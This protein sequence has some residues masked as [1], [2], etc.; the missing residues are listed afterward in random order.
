M[1]QQ[2]SFYLPWFLSLSVGLSLCLSLCFSSCGFSMSSRDSLEP[3]SS[4]TGLLT[5][6]LR[7]IVHV[8]HLEGSKFFIFYSPLFITQPR[9]LC[10]TILTTF[11]S[12]QEIQ[13]KG[14]RLCFLMGIPK[15][16]VEL[17]FLIRQWQ[18]M[19][20]GNR[21]EI[22]LQPPVES[23]MCYMYIIFRSEFT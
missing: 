19:R 4:T 22:L 2:E 13:E 9:K 16:S 23:V 18:G 1:S 3:D 6:W 20:R 5:Q 10:S 7:A 21:L 8:L 14:I 12:L 17:F 15:R 11:C